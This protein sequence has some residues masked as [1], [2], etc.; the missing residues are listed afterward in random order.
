LRQKETRPYFFNCRCKGSV[1]G[2][3][4]KGKKSNYFFPF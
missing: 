1:R 4:K 2:K 3:C